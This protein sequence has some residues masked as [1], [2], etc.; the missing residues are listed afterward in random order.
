MFLVQQTT[1]GTCGK[2]Y[3]RGRVVVVW[4]QSPQDIDIRELRA[5]DT[6][7][8]NC[9]GRGLNMLPLRTTQ[10]CHRRTLRTHSTTILLTHCFPTTTK[11]GFI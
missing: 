7:I 3:G 5:L 11:G 8:Y 6:Q 2:K 10:L 1:H 4:L 9:L